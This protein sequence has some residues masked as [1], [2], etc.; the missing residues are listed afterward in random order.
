MSSGWKSKVS[1]SSCSGVGA[2]NAHPGIGDQW[3]QDSLRP[4]WERDGVQIL[5]QG[6]VWDRVPSVPLGI[7]VDLSCDRDQ[8]GIGFPQ[9][10][11]EFG[12]GFI[13]G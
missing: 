6:S 9:S 11:W 8:F 7:W 5:G 3:G 2:G 1:G 12:V 10:R 4:S 13:P